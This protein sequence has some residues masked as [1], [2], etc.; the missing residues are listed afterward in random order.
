MLKQKKKKRI[1]SLKKTNKRERGEKNEAEEQNKER[2]E[3]R[4]ME[5]PQGNRGGWPELCVK[6]TCGSEGGADKET[7]Q[8]RKER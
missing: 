3:R 1:C 2:N 5:R 6:A 7:E 4:I 8:V